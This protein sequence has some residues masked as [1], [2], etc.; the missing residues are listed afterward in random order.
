MNESWENGEKEFLK[1]LFKFMN[2][3]GDE[4]RDDSIIVPI[5]ESISLAYS[6]DNVSQI[7]N[8]PNREKSFICYGRWAASVISNDIIACGIAPKGLALDVGMDGFTEEDFF[9]FVQGVLDVCNKYGMKYEGGNLNTGKNVSGISWGLSDAS[10]IISRS[11]ARDN[12]IL[13]AT[14]NVGTGWAIKLLGEDIRNITCYSK[15]LET[16]KETPMVNLDLFKEIWDLD[17]VL[18]GMDLTDGII[19]FGYEIFERTGLGV[20]FDF[21]NNYSKFLEETSEVLT[22]PIDALRFE[23]GYDTPFAHG[24]CI[25]EDNLGKVIEVFKKYKIDFTI[26][27]RVDSHYNGVFYSSKNNLKQLP[28]YW[29]DKVRSYGGIKSWRSTILPLFI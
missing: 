24:W 23:P 17:V 8:M 9:C 4:W 22:V 13:L 28:K 11:G 16:Y 12:S 20:V 14:C 5:S 10:K 26:L 29:D 7:Y 6:I 3:Q 15:E 19:E 18:C 2:V 1:K 21:S 27:G 25:S